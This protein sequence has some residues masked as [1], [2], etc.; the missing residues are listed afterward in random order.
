MQ[1][2][3]KTRLGK[4]PYCSGFVAVYHSAD[5]LSCYCCSRYFGGYYCGGDDY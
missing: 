4:I 1:Q 5:S 3:N 2:K